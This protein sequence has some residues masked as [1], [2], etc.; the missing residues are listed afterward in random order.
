M[1]NLL[2]FNIS[3]KGLFQEKTYTLVSTTKSLFNHF[4]FVYIDVFNIVPY[5]I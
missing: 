1:I 5:G 2:Y 4:E 3:A